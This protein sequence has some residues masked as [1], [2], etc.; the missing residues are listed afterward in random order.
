MLVGCVGGQAR[1]QDGHSRRRLRLAVHDDEVP[2][3]PLA[4]LGE[5][6]D[7]VGRQPA[8]RLGDGPQRRQVQLGEARPVEQVEGVRDARERRRPGGADQPPEAGV[9]DRQLGEQQRRAPLQVAV[10]HRQ[11]VAVAERQR[12]RGQV[13]GAQGERR[14]DGLGVGLQVA[15]R[16]AHELGRPGRPGGAQQQRQVVV[17]PVGG[18]RAALLRAPAGCRR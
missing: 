18:A 11:A 8:A 10:Q 3:A 7:L 17:Q 2:A 14:R 15:V 5:A 6:A 4:E 13:R 9:D 12:R 16:Q 1:R